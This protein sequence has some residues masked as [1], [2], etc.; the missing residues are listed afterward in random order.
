MIYPDTKT[1]IIYFFIL[2]TSLLNNALSLWEENL[3]Q[4]L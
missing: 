2:V 4:S 3:Y 1:Q